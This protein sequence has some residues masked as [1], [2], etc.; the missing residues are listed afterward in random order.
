M[1]FV[2]KKYN[3]YN[4]NFLNFK[5]LTNY[6]FLNKIPDLKHDDSE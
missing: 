3:K 6:Y 4:F 5:M 1:I 2:D